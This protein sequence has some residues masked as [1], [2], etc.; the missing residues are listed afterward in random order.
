VTPEERE[1]MNWLVLRIQ[2]EKD[3]EK[4]SKLVEELTKLIEQKDRRFPPDSPK[5]T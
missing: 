4:F 1:R 3:R 2:Q 5:Q